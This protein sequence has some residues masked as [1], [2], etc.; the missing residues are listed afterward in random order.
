MSRHCKV[1]GST[2]SNY[3]VSARN[4]DPAED[5]GTT[6]AACRDCHRRDH[7]IASIDVERSTPQRTST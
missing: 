6:W 2:D 3:T 4:F 1:C 5:T 7:Q